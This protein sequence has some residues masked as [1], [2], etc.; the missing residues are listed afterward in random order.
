MK[1]IYKKLL[2]LL[3]FLPF[4]AF[5][6]SQLS[7]VVTDESTG[8]PLPG[9]NVIVKGTSNGA[10]TD[11]DGN[12]SLS[13]VSN[14]AVIEFTFLG[15][16]SKTVNFT[17]QKVINV[18]MSEDMDVLDEV[19]MVGYGSVK[20]KDATG[21]V[22]VISAKD[23]NKGAN[24]TADNLINGKIAGVS[25]NAGGGRPGEVPTI[26]IR[27]GSSLLANN[28]PL[29][30]VDGLPM[31]TSVLASI[32][33][34][35]IESYSVLKDA[36]ATAIYGSRAANGVILITTKRGSKTLQVDYNIQ[37]GSGNKF[38][39]VEAFSADEYRN[40]VAR[41]GTPEQ[42]AR[43]GNANT[44]WQNEIYRRT[45]FIDNN[46]SMRGN[47]FKTIPTRLTIGNTYTEGLR[48]T[49][50]LN[51]NTVSLNMNPSF[52]DDHLK[53][54]LAV[55]YTNSRRRN[56][57]GVEG[58]AIRFD[59]TQPVYDAESPFE[60]F[61]EHRTGNTIADF[62]PI[63]TQNPVATLLQTNNRSENFKTFGN[64]EVDYKFH[65][66]PELRAVVNAGYD[67]D[68]GYG[69]NFTSRFAVSGPRRLTNGILIPIGN[70]DYSEGTG[71]NQLLDA[72]LVYAKD[73]E[74][75]SYDFTA[76]YSYQKFETSGS[77]TRNRFDP[78]TEGQSF[79]NDPTVLIGFFG[80]SNITI[81]D[82]YLITLSYRRDGTSRFGEE[83][84]WGNFPAAA[85]AW[86][87][88]DEFFSESS[89]ISDLKLRL[90]W[91]ITGQQD[92]NVG[93]FFL[94]QFSVGDQFSQYQFG[95]DFIGVGVPSARNPSIKWEETYTY[96]AGIDFGFNNNRLNGSLDVFYKLSYDL[97][98]TAPFADG[99][100]F[101]NEG[102]TNIG[103][104]S[105]KG[106]E[107]NLNYDV[108]RTDNVNWNVGFN[109]TRFERRIDALALGSPIFFGGAGGGTGATALIQQEGFTPGS[110][111][112]YKQLYNNDGS[113]IEGAFGDLNGDGI[114][115]ADDRYIYKNADPDVILGFS[116]S[117]NYKNFDL[118][119]N[120]RANI[121]SRILNATRSARSYSSLIQN[122]VME[123][124]SPFV[125]VTNF[126][127]QNEQTILSDMFIENGSF[128]RMD[129]ATAGYTFPRWLDGKASLRLFTGV[130]N[131]FVI[132]K[133]TGLDPEINGG[134][135]N[136]IYPRQRQILF[137]AN[138]KF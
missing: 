75:V 28:D 38:N 39:T 30:V 76:G 104:M 53:L 129:F 113:P 110:F 17:G 19:V 114:V 59:P 103:D 4:L 100:N 7:G 123:N 12:F 130:Q 10:S 29:V 125:E 109:A 54:R 134:I 111:F 118:G 62:A 40:Y 124:I 58:S 41:V 55:N 102:A 81:N 90:G 116:T 80:R 87:L 31:N 63:A 115:T 2:F 11:F 6:Q 72:Y 73:R 77:F 27:G 9:V 46:L 97:F 43:L 96:N 44:N 1:T 122:G 64:F 5:S 133:Y 36:S 8:Q 137:G 120:L 71:T 127:F 74:K 119:F 56:A 25:I 13:N 15:Y 42:L 68:T 131:P 45:D 86:K 93:T 105:V 23:F 101:S 112:V 99:S 121:G 126:E 83:N 3:L 94:S 65:F 37:Y 136:T 108:I 79:V 34:N 92:I 89:K 106:I 14:G 66:L 51:R 98:Q 48:L 84:R 21:S 70:S 57:P 107:F 24:V 67:H 47:L 22:S 78:D 61:F 33:P 69:E 35:D 18:T 128:L 117:F 60:G 135:D 91:G 82:K 20:K 32:N 16:K 95:N 88:R 138:I 85:F 26:R 132:T 49:D 52:F 50:F